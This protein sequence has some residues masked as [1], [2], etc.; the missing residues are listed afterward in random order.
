MGGLSSAM[1][2]VSGSRLSTT[3]GR[4]P[5]NIINQKGAMMGIHVD[6][7]ADLGVPAWNEAVKELV[8]TRDKLEKF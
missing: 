8:D 3:G 1:S 7:M 5:V 4:G 6:P 2:Q